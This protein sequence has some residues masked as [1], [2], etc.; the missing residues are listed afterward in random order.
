MRPYV[1]GIDVGGT[2]IKAGLVNPS[3]RVR[4]RTVLP[5]KRV[6]KYLGECVMK[7]FL[8]LVLLASVG[9]VGF[10]IITGKIEAREQLA[11]VP[12]LGV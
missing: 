4:F 7:V 8:I 3:G 2:N 1:I 9:F 12:Q 10:I 6:S 5:T 11:Q